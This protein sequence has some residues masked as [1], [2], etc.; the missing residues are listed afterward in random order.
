[1]V[2]YSDRGSRFLTFLSSIVYRCHESFIFTRHLFVKWTM[3][4]ENVSL[5]QLVRR[6]VRVCTRF[7]VASSLL[8]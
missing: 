3:K 7:T 6:L 2:E 8:L 4:P 5:G 1:M